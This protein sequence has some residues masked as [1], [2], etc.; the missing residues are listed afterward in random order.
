[1][2]KMGNVKNKR[3]VSDVV[4]NTFIILLTIIAVSILSI[5]VVNFIRDKLESSGSCFDTLGKVKLNPEFNCNSL[6]KLDKTN[7]KDINNNGCDDSYFIE[8]I[9]GTG[10]TAPNILVSVEVGDIKV[11]GLVFR[12]SAG[13]KTKSYTIK[14]GTYWDGISEESVQYIKIANYK[15]GYANSKATALILP[16]KN[17]AR[18]YIINVDELVKHNSGAFAVGFACATPEKVELAPIINGDEQCDIVD[19][20]AFEPCT[21]L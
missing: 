1:M 9:D 16:K 21:S 12:I 10:D 15:M 20:M 14:N 17:E 13:G 7:Y 3:A 4:A 5:F 8:L 18:S 6:E 2:K 19:S 11:D